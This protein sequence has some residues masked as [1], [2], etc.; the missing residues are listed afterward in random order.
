MVTIYSATNASQKGRLRDLTAFHGG[1]EKEFI[2]FYYVP[3]EIS[4]SVEPTYEEFVIIGRSSPIQ[5]Y[6]STGARSI[7]LELQ[8]FAEEDARTEVFDKIQWIQSLKYPEYIGQMIKPP[9]TVS[10]ILGRFLALEGIL[11]SADVAWKAPYDTETKYPMYAVTTITIEESVKVPYDYRAVRR[12]SK[13]GCASE[14]EVGG[15]F[16]FSK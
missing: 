12:S 10:L 8:F 14:S 6:S 5:G 3:E 7:S 11:K 16:R 9:H 2:D 1:K 15:E 4:D 13:I